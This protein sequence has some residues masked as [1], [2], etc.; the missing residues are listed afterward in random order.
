MVTQCTNMRVFL[1]E[2]NSYVPIIHF[3]FQTKNRYSLE[4]HI[5]RRHTDSRDFHCDMCPKSFKTSS[6]LKVRKK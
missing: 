3:D 4:R 6:E 5:Q 2:A 1:E